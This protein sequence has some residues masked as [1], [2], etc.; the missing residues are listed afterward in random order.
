MD[1]KS[2]LLQSYQSP[3]TIRRSKSSMVIFP[4]IHS[5]R[6]CRAFFEQLFAQPPGRHTGIECLV[7]PIEHLF[8]RS[9]LVL[10]RIFYSPAA[11]NPIWGNTAQFPPNVKHRSGSCRS[12]LAISAPRI[13]R[14]CPGWIHRQRADNKTAFLYKTAL[15]KLAVF[16]KLDLCV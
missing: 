2:W 5:L 3:L 1:Y 4:A 14:H 7:G 12:L 10:F 13:V 8:G 9:S 15:L 6:F 11:R 16:H